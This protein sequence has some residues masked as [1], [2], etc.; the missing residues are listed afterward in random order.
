M[1]VENLDSVLDNIPGIYQHIHVLCLQEPKCT[2]EIPPL[3]QILCISILPKI[4]GH[5]SEMCNLK[6]LI[7]KRINF[8]MLPN[9]KALTQALRQALFWLT[10]LCLIICPMPLNILMSIL[11]IIVDVDILE[12]G[13]L[14]FGQFGISR[15]RD[16]CTIS[17]PSAAMC[18]ELPYFHIFHLITIF[19]RGLSYPPT[20]YFISCFCL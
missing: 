7:L 4:F 6:E 12:L 15:P 14:Q 1:S 19:Y 20:D 9:S 17:I 11:H 2:T 5:I 3:F 10:T 13:I 16:Y 18:Y 8:W